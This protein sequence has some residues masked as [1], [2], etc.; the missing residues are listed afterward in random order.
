MKQVIFMGAGLAASISLAAAL[1]PDL[2]KMDTGKLPRPAAQQDLT[3]AKDIKPLIQTSCIKCHGP[4]KPK[5]GF[6]VDSRDSLIK[7]GE[8]KKPAVVPGQSARS[9]IVL[10]TSDLVAEMEMP[11]KDKRPKFA[12]LTPAQIGIL[13]A[14]IDQGAK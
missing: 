9:P 13:R 3:Y 2:S 12:P 1:E 11:P 6:R 8:S 14:W 10:F 4:E 7:G 5:S